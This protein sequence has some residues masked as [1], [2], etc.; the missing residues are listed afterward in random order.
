VGYVG[1]HDGS[2]YIYPWDWTCWHI[3]HKGIK[4]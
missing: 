2:L 4:N 3:P 1:P